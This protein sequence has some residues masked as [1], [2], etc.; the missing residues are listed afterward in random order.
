MATISAVLLVFGLFPPKKKRPE[1]ITSEITSNQRRLHSA[2][3]EI[4]ETQKELEAINL[5]ISSAIAESGGKKALLEAKQK[6]FSEKSETLLSLKAEM[7]T[8]KSALTA[9]CEPFSKMGDCSEIALYIKNTLQDLSAADVMIS[10]AAD[11]TNCQSIKEAETRLAALDSD[12]TLRGLT[13]EAVAAA[14]DEYRRLAEKGAQLRGEIA[15]LKSN[16]K[17]LIS[18][19]Q[20]VPII[21][22]KIKALK[23]NISSMERFCNAA[24]TALCVLTDSFAAMREGYGGILEAETSNIF[25]KLTS[26]AYTSLDISKDFEIKTHKEGVFGAKDWQFLSA[27]TADQ[28]YLSLRIALSKL[29]DKELPLIM[30]DSLAQYDTSRAATALEFLSDHAKEHQLLLF[31][32]HEDIKTKAESL[33]ANTINM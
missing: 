4:T 33:G 17:A 20:T 6:E 31:T 7:L 18:S 25:S 13:N 23:E 32:C 27:G 28:A 26:G 9:L 29:I 21:E 19:G 14:K 10:M 16:L 22:E 30:D 12:D 11:S 8:A 15:T 2:L 24:D 5:S 1:K 3:F